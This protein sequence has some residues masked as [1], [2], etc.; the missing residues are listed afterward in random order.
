MPK[1]KKSTV[2]LFLRFEET[3]EG[4]LRIRRYA[5]PTK[6][7]TIVSATE[8]SHVRDGEENGTLLLADDDFDTSEAVSRLEESLRRAF[9]LE[10]DDPDEE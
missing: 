1:T 6:D 7:G 10:P 2:S 8:M 4:S 5:Y 9:Q 3:S